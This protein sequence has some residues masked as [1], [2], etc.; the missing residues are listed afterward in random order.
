MLSVIEMGYLEVQDN[1][2]LEIDLLFTLI[3]NPHGLC[4]GTWLATDISGSYMAN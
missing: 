2:L 3:K 4:F 1:K